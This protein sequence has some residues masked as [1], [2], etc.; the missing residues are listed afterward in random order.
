MAISV[1]SGLSSSSCS[2]SG[3]LTEQKTRTKHVRPTPQMKE[4]HTT[5]VQ[6]S[7]SPAL[8]WLESLQQFLYLG[9]WP[10]FSSTAKAKEWPQ[11]AAGLPTE[12][13]P[14]FTFKKEL[15]WPSHGP[16]FSAKSGARAY[17]MLATKGSSDEMDSD[18][19][20]KDFWKRFMRIFV[21]KS[22]KK[23]T[24]S[25]AKLVSDGSSQSTNLNNLRRQFGSNHRPCSAG[26]VGLEHGY[27]WIWTGN[28]S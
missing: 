18:Y 16:I 8:Q 26:R 5:W 1:Q 10:K 27:L 7:A 3:S 23:P 14:H 2:I 15:R 13:C 11:S 28:A 24:E 22:W 6:T 19:L 21:D 25:I 4:A 17:A 9:P 20:G 12:T